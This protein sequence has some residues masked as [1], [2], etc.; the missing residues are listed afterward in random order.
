MDSLEIFIFAFFFNWLPRKKSLSPDFFP[1]LWP[2]IIWKGKKVHRKFIEFS[3]DLCFFLQ[4]MP[5][6]AIDYA[7]VPI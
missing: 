6:C 2:D 4:E 7:Y 1:Y 3:T 5:A